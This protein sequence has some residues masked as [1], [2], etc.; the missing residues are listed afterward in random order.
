M[1]PVHGVLSFRPFPRLAK[2]LVIRLKSQI[3]SIAYNI[4]R[5]TFKKL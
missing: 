3:K 4:F 5:Q 1:A 2:T